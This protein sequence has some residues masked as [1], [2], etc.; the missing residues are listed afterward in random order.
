MAEKGKEEKE[1]TSSDKKPK[2]KE[3]SDKTPKPKQDSD[4]KPKP[5]HD[6]ILEITGSFGKYQL[7]LCFIVFLSKFFIAFNQLAIVFYAPPVKYSCGDSNVEANVCPCNSPKYNY[8]IF[9]RTIV[10]EWNLICDR[11]WLASFMQL[12][13]QSGT[14]V[15]SLGFGALSDRFGRRKPFIGACMMQCVF[16][17]T[18]AFLPGYTLGY[19]NFG[20]Y[21]Y[22]EQSPNRKHTKKRRS[23]CSR[24]SEE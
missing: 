13:F 17:I 3:D 5:K 21:R 20:T 23:L 7:W 2:P 9:S 1:G 4:Q 24:G 10:T 15:G 12:I 22:N 19:P 11:K 14:L 6:M 8:A 16:G 18:G